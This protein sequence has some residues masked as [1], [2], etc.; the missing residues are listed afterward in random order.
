MR[1]AL[2]SDIHGNM[3]ALE[4]V[5][6]DAKANGVEKTVFLGDYI[7]DLPYSN[8]V[9]DAL[10]STKNAESIAGN[11][12]IRL[13]GLRADDEE[14]AKLQQIGILY[15]TLKE[16]TPRALAFLNALPE[17]KTV[18]LEYGGRL[19]ATHT[20]S[21][22]RKSGRTPCNSSYM[23]AK[24][25]REAPFTREAYLS[26]LDEYYNGEMAPELTA[27]DARVIAYGHNH[28][29]GHG[30]FKEKWIVDPGSCGQPL[31]FDT[32]A[33]YTILDETK[34]GIRLSERRVEYDAEALIADA[35][36][37]ACYKAG[38]V[39]SELVYASL[40]RGTDFGP[41]FLM[42]AKRIAE[43]K[44]ERGDVFENDTVE[45]AYRELR[46]RM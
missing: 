41:E 30:R 22:T 25:M 27:I 17:E 42:I 21:N 28:L 19:Y 23:Y 39:W 40:R 45:E 43:R 36:T 16:L 9:V 46:A 37:K 33:A 10:I 12:E 4:K 8:E 24:T 13:R 2:I 15:Q 29:Q 11:K 20:L 6:A 34:S 1:I 3:P 7:F 35:R 32:R 5:L 44:G 26:M 38:R 31:D 18:A 14:R